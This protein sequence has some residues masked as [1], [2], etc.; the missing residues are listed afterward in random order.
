M[1]HT[2]LLFIAMSLAACSTANKTVKEPFI[3]NIRSSA[4]QAGTIEAQFDK[5][6]SIG[7]LRKYEITLN[8]YPIEDA[9]CLRYRIDFTT[10]YQFWNKEGRETFLK[11]L[12]NYKE[13]YSQRNFG[14]SSNKSKRKYGTA[15]GYLI[16]QF[17]QYSTRFSGNP[18]IEIGYFFKDKA[19]YF[20]VNQRKTEYLDPASRTRKESPE[21]TMYFTRVQADSLAAFFDQKYLQGLVTTSSDTNTDTNGNFYPDEY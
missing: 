1:K 18:N 10:Y 13:D 5:F 21:I 19:P 12:E 14:K 7:G 9:V 17:F 6:L 15:E 20:T 3:V 4:I 11:G 8:Y 16:W 2:V